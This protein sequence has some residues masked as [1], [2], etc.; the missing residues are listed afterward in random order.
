MSGYFMVNRQAMRRPILNPMGYK[1]LLEV[2]GKQVSTRSLKWVTFS[3][4]VKTAKAGEVTWQ[5]YI[6]YILHLLKSVPAGRF[7]G[8]KRRFNSRLIAFFALV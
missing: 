4:S 7:G 1:I 6:E 3:K 2:I 5:Q 8:L